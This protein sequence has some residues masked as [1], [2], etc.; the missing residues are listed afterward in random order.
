MR[1]LKPAKKQH[2]RTFALNIQERP[3]THVDGG[4]GGGG[5]GGAVAAIAA[6]GCT[7]G[8]TGAG[9]VGTPAETP[10]SSAAARVAQPRVPE[11]SQL[12]SSISRSRSSK[13][14]PLSGV[15]LFLEGRSL[16]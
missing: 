2:P 12:R 10:L 5:G 9:A 14:K 7:D 13:S 15:F 1:S 4:G 16:Y 8:S 6:V 11:G 3:E